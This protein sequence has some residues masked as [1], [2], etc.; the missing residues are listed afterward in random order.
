MSSWDI[1]PSNLVPCG[2]VAF[3]LALGCGPGPS[4]LQIAISEDP[5]SMTEE[6][7][8]LAASAISC[9]DVLRLL[10][11]DWNGLRAVINNAAGHRFEAE[12]RPH[13]LDA[14]ME[15]R[16]ELRL[17]DLANG[18]EGLDMWLLRIPRMAMKDG[19]DPGPGQA[20]YL[21]FSAQ[22]D[23]F[24]VIGS[25]TIPCSFLHVESTP[26]IGPYHQ[27]LVGFDMVLDERDRILLWRDQHGSH[28]GD[29]RFELKPGAFAVCARIG[30]LMNPPNE[31]DA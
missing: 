1:F 7:R 3:T 2:V 31:H 10:A 16:P 23:L 15:V 22:H 9:G 25:D 14:C 6:Q 24:E 8:E 27:I 11:E 13:V 17:A 30:A 21:N 19:A 29:L 5:V 28:A 4:A 12:Y 20:E 26:A 18:L